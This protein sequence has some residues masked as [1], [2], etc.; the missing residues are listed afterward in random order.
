MLSCVTCS[1]EPALLDGVVLDDLER[2]LP[3]PMFLWFRCMS[4]QFDQ[5]CY[6]TLPTR[7]IKDGRNGQ[8]DIG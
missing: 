6:E 8:I 2:S 5:S 1:R 4:V 3:T 7:H